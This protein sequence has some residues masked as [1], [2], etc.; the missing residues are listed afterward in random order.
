MQLWDYLYSEDAAVAFRLLAE[1]GVGGKTYPLGGGKAL[2][3][4][5]YIITLRDAID[6]A[7]P[8]GLGEIPYGPLQVMHL[9][10]DITALRRDT[11]FTPATDFAT[12]IR[13]TI[14]AAKA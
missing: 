8:L 1:R 12:G 11:G 2:P 5:D 4:K 6:P 7:L 13:A 9:E 14:A 10:A 3:L